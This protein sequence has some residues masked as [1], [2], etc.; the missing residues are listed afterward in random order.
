VY[1]S[2][3]EAGASGV[4]QLWLTKA[5]RHCFGMPVAGATVGSPHS[6]RGQPLARLGRER[7]TVRGPT[8]FRRTAP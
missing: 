4:T 8:L 6:S 7:E 1:D 2:A 5:S 3:G